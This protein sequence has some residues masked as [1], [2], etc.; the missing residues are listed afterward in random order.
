MQEAIRQ[1]QQRQAADIQS[2]I[3]QGGWPLSRRA[4]RRLE[5]RFSRQMRRD[6][7]GRRR[8]PAWAPAIVFFTLGLWFLSMAAHH[9]GSDAMRFLGL[10]FLLAAVAF[11]M[12]GRGR[13]NAEKGAEAERVEAAERPP[14]DAKQAIRQP[15]P[16]S[17]PD[18]TEALCEKLIQEIR[19]SPQALRQVVHRPEETIVSLRKACAALRERE[20]SLRALVTPE[21][22]RRLDSERAEL[23]KRVESET[24]EVVRERLS[25][26]LK[27]LDD[28]VKQRSNLLMSAARLE[29][30]RTR[31]HYALENLYTQVLSV[32]SV[33]AASADVA[34]AGLRQSLSRLSEEVSAV[35]ESLE[36]VSRGDESS[37]TPVS[38]VS[39]E[40]GSRPGAD[41]ER[42]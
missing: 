38:P 30:E 32:K 40:T 1:G 34:G 12:R 21:D 17:Q 39:S 25:S 10:G 20:H 11:L 2:W 19:A 8:G 13:G 7:W 26:A 31:I 28:Q 5:R 22:T 24:D 16:R 14:V 18:R 42:S 15:E 4:R 27:S 6:E 9:T 3:N 35:A 36:A 37:F 29:A 23:T 41:R 33:D